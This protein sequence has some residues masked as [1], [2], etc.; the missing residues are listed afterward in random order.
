M[1]IRSHVRDL[2][3]F[4]SFNVIMLLFRKRFPLFM[5]VGFICRI[6][7]MYVTASGFTV[8]E[9]WFLLIFV[10]MVFFSFILIRIYFVHMSILFFEGI[11]LCESHG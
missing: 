1:Q 4:V 5:C 9:M 6:L 7:R 8:V 11:F 10:M 2:F 3:G